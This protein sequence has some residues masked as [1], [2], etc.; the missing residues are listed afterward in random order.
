MDLT[1]LLRAMTLALLSEPASS[2]ADRKPEPPVATVETAGVRVRYAPLPSPVDPAAPWPLG[3]LETTVTLHLDGRAIEPGHYALVCHPGA[4]H[5][6]ATVAFVRLEPS[7]WLR[8]EDLRRLPQGD[9][10][11]RAPVRFDVAAGTTPRLIVSLSPGKRRITLTAR[12]GNAK[13]VRE[14]TR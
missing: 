7:Q 1:V 6:E 12:Y 8:L 5:G 13:V 11:F 3:R 10:L 14:F 4:D 9:P 2:P